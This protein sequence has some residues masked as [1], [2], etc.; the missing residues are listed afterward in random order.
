MSGPKIQVAKGSIKCYLGEGPHW[1]PV[2][3]EL[4]YVDIFG[5]AVLR[6]VPSTQECHK[7]TVGMN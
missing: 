1:D 3:N 4:L 6:Y 5:K 7:V 2:K